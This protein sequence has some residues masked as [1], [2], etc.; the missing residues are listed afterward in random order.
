M[1]PKRSKN[2][3]LHRTFSLRC[4]VGL[5]ILGVIHGNLGYFQKS[6]LKKQTKKDDILT[7]KITFSFLDFL[8]GNFDLFT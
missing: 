4:N 1:A 5:G 3:N 2:G 7:P 8:G 6:F